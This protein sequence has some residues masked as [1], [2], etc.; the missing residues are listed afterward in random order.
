MSSSYGLIA[1]TAIKQFDVA[2][3]LMPVLIIPMMLVSG[4]FVSL[5]QVPKFFYWM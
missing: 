4:F 3:S 2:I 1:S 5:D